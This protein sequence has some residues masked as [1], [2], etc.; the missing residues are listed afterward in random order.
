M[1]KKLFVKN[2]DGSIT[3]FGRSGTGKAMLGKAFTEKK[4]KKDCFDCLD[5][6]DE[7]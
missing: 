7:K 3:F 1:P 4:K 6:S 2:D 5:V